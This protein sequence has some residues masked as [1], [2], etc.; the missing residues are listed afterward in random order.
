MSFTEWMKRV[1]KVIAVSFGG[2]THRDISD[3][4]YRDLFED[5]VTPREAAMAAIDNETEGLW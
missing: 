5:G 1:D 4:T 2:L 3:F